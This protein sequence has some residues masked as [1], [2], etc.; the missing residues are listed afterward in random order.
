MSA[1]SMGRSEY[2]SLRVTIQD[3]LCC[4]GFG[5]EH[6]RVGN[7]AIPY[8]ESRNRPAPAGNDVEESPHRS[9]NRAVMAVDEKPCAVVVRLFGMPRKV[10][11]TDPFEREIRQ[12]VERRESVIGGG[13]EDVV[14]VE[15]QSATRS[16]GEFAN[17]IGLAH[18]GVAKQRVGGRIFEQ[19]RPADRLLNITDVISDS[20]ERRLRV[21]KRQ[22]IIEVG[23]LVSRPR[24]M[25][26]NKRRLVALHKSGK[27]S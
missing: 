22:K 3:R 5:L 11:F 9:G 17:E 26:G 15:Q 4:H 8:D 10:D 12:V 2:E 1:G 16:S 25:F 21:R 23:R 27:P 7:L 24:E 14:D 6:G 18:G 19:N 13:N 20:G